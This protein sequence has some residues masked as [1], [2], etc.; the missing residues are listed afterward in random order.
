VNPSARYRSAD[1]G[2]GLP[3]AKDDMKVTGENI[4]RRKT[5]GSPEDQDCLKITNIFRL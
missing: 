1:M 3:K 5:K 4:R 2:S